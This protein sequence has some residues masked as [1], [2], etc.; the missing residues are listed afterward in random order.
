MMFGIQNVVTDFIFFENVRYFLEHAPEK[1]CLV[2][3]GSNPDFNINHPRVFYVGPLDWMTLISLYK[4][5]SKFLHLA[6]LDHCPN[7]VIDASASGCQIVCSSA[8]GTKEISGSNSIIIEEDEWDF[9]PVRLYQPPGLD[10]LRATS[11][12][13]DDIDL[14]I[15]TVTRDYLNVLEKIKQ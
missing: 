2:I 11:N 7:V 3:A 8:G 10:F 5:S 4:R 12:K 1:A 15:A 14:N 6:W 9:E 13:C